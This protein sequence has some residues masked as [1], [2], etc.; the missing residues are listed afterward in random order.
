MIRRH[1]TTLRLALMAADAASALVL[2]VLVSILRFG[3]DHWYAAWTEVHV[4]PVPLASA[5]AVTWSCI[6]WVLGLYRL[7]TRWSWRSDVLDVARAT[8]LVAVVAFTALFW[9]K[10]PNVSRLFLVL[11]FA[12]QGTVTLASRLALRAFFRWIRSRGYNARFVLIVGTGREAERFANRIEARRELGLRV[13]GHVAV[14][15]RAAATAAAATARGAPLVA[16]AGNGR[17][18]GHA[19]P[20]LALARPGAIGSGAPLPATDPADPPLARD[21][22][23]TQAPFVPSRPI[24]GT[25]DAIQAILHDQVVDEVAI[26]LPAVDWP[27]IEPVTRLCEEEG[28]IVR[29]PLQ[30]AG[31]TLPGGRLEDFDGTPILSLVYGPDRA[32]GLALKRVLDI[33]GAALALVVFSPVLLGIAILV[34]IRDGSPILFR[35]TRIGL[36]GRPFTLYKFRTMIPDAEARLAELLALNEIEGQ[37]FKLSNDPRLTRTGRFLRRT[38]LDEL[39]QFW[40]VLRG[41]MSIVG[42]RPPLPREVAGYDLWHRR[43][44]SMKPGITGLWQVSA[45]HEEDF[46]RWVELDLA[47]IDRWSLW[48]D[49]KIM[50]RTIPAMLQG[51]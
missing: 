6:L 14:P 37:A 26:C 38:S 33:L 12:A 27:I 8:I 19:D 11:L 40:N 1:T 41:E 4:S 21:E 36:Q 39:P 25:L 30:S 2:F 5:Y 9:F 48:L 31:F 13:V 10:L 51:R 49:F 7:R 44:L 22:G 42:P 15:A 50:A 3:A 28:K 20:V 24:L 29:I 35:Q 17:G 16:T 18:E 46:D 34:R 43:R 23:L 32:V 47:Y 45:R